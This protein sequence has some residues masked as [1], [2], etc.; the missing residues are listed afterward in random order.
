MLTEFYTVE[1]PLDIVR[2]EK[3]N[4]MILTDH[5]NNCNSRKTIYIGNLKKTSFHSLTACTGF[6]AYAS[7]QPGFQRKW[8]INL[9]G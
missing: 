9:S 4:E 8:S 1:N 6:S 2:Q 3:Y 7:S 5:Y